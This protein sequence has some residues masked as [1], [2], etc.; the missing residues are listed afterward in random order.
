MSTYKVRIYTCKKH[1]L[2]VLEDSSP[3]MVG[4]LAAM[5]PF[6]REEFILSKI[7]KPDCKTE[8]RTREVKE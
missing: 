8:T 2:W 5:C 7:G 4:G 3:L 1:P 6:C